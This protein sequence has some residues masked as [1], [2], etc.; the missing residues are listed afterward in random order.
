VERLIAQG[1]LSNFAA[2]AEQGARS[3]VATTAPAQTPVA[4]STFATG[5][6][7]GGHGIFDFLRRDPKNYLPDLALNRY[8]QKNAFLPPKVVNLRRGVPFWERLSQAGVPSIILRCP[9]TYPPDAVAG[10]MLSGMGVPDARGGFGTSTFYSTRAG[11]VAGEAEQVIAL[12]RP[13]D[14]HVRT[15]LIGPRN[16]RERTESHLEI[17]LELALDRKGLVL[18]S[19]ASPRELALPLGGWSDWL[20]VRFPVGKLQSL[21]GILRFYLRNLEPEIELLA[22]PVNFDPTEPPYPISH[23]ARYSAELEEA[24]GPYATTGMVE[25]HG[26]LSNGRIDEPAFLAQCAQVWDEREAMLLHELDRFDEGVLFCLFDTSD[27]A[28]HML[29]RHLEPDHPANQESPANPEFAQAVIDQ[30]RRADLVIRTAREALGDDSRTLVI[31]LSDH[32]F[33]GFQ[34]GVHVNTWLLE[35]GYLALRESVE[36]GEQAPDLLRAVDWTRTKAYALGLGGIYLNRQGREAEGIVTSDDAP[37]IEREI[38]DGLTALEDKERHARPIRRVDS[39]HTLYRG[40]HVEDAPDLLV[41]FESGY[42]VSWSTSLGG[43]AAGDLVEANTK[44][45]AGDHV[46]DPVLVP[47]V[48]AMSRPFR[49]QGARLLDL[50]PTVLEAMGVPCPPEMEGSSLCHDS[51]KSS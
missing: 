41:Q 27:R 29:W 50:A 35:N 14:G 42:R 36:P 47:G 30:Y 25:D 23:P 9:C 21:R 13:V 39:R 22:S 51:R 43:L 5:Q 38:A 31:A 17:E 33:G 12:E 44:A 1:A 15:H 4:W 26:A 32:G 3:T 6:N 16:L 2:L 34:R 11:L 7:P 37:T 40:P 24:I 45:W 49:T 48:L 19:N 18:R 28:Q 8:E 20:R 46:V 10:R